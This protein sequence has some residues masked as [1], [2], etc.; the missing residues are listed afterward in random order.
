MTV[1]RFRWPWA[2]QSD[3]HARRTL[4]EANAAVKETDDIVQRAERL[5]HEVSKLARENHL[6]DAVIYSIQ[7]KK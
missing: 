2:S 4:Q 5:R 3:P 1:S 7:H 6:A